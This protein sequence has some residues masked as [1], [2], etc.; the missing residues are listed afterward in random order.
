MKI[1]DQVTVNDTS[2]SKFPFS[3][4]IIDIVDDNYIVEDQECDVFQTKKSCL[5]L[6]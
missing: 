5:E 6:D 3:A 4:T 2:V 1:N